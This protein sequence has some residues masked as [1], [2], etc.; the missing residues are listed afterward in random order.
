MSERSR[1]CFTKRYAFFQRQPPP[2][3][4][5]ARQ[6]ARAVILR[7]DCLSFGDIICHVHY[8]IEIAAVAASSYM[9]QTDKSRMCARYR[10]EFLQSAE[11]PLVWPLALKRRAI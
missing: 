1:Q 2:R 3:R 8:A 7:F 4:N 10:L 11:F 9:Q 5:V 6:R